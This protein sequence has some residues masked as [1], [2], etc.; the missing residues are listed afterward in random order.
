MMK[1][2]P[3]VLCLLLLISS[4]RHKDKPIVN[5]SFADS[6]ITHYSPSLFAKTSDSNLIFWEKRMANLPENFVN[7]PKYAAALSSR[8]HLY[9]KIDDLVKA[10]SLFN[11]SNQANKENEPGIL[12][13]LASFAILQHRFPQADSL[14]KK[15]IQLEGQSVSNTFL[16]FDISFERGRYEH[17]KNLLQALKTYNP[18]GYLFRR[19]KFE[20]YDG[21]LDS[22]IAC[23]LQ[24]AEKAGNNN[25]LR[26]TALS[27]TADLYIHKGNIAEAYKLY[28][29]SINIDAADFHSIMGIGWIS[30][31]HD[32]NDSLAEK[33]F[34][35]IHSKNHAPD[36]L[37]KLEQV[38]EA[39]N[40]STAQK[41][42]ANKF[43]AQANQP[44]Y[45]L[46]YSKYL[47]DLY[48]GILNNPSKAVA[49]AEREIIN[50]PTPQTYA[51]YV[52]AL[53]CNNEK[54][55][56]YSVFRNTVSGKPLEGP[57]LYYMGKLMQ[58]MNKG[59]NAQQFFKAAY[60][61]RYDL[62]PAKQ[63]DLEKNLE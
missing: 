34:R 17:S 63:R 37:L 8:F 21:S 9:G 27:N 55:K 1:N 24:A 58:S 25:Y 26:Q 18:F 43:A 7:G 59:Y 10:D 31:V 44:V 40:D 28:V 60:K 62:S 32:Q 13:T 11:Q 48:T 45:G 53:L 16:D 6:L 39:R 20:H 14:L 12:R 33:I 61:N 29:K 52:W 54:E 3:A 56:A 35:F 22:A 49:L 42:W 36:A 50:R 19:S 41:E 51:W 15:A 23:M 38:A 2:I 57:E 5:S 46:M 4:C 47:I 30:L